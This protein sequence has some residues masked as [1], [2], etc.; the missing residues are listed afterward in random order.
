M[1]GPADRS[2]LRV[3]A[4]PESRVSASGV[5]L[6]LRLP[7][8][9]RTSPSSTR[10]PAHSLERAAMLPGV[11]TAAIAGN[12]PLDPGFTNSFTIVGREAEAAFV[13]RDLAAPGLAI[14][15]PG[16]EPAAT[17]ADGCCSTPIRPQA[18]PVVLI[19][20]G[21]G[22]AVLSVGRSDRR[23]HAVLGHVAHDCRRRC[24][25]A[26]PRC[27]QHRRR[28][29]PTLRSHRHHLRAA[30]SCCARPN[31]PSTLAASAERVIHEIDPGLAVF[32]VE[33]LDLTISRSISQ[34][35]FTTALLGGFA[36]LALILAA[37]GIHG[38]VSYNVERRRRRSGSGWRSAPAGRTSTG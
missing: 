24:E 22:A 37:V 16:G 38:L 28:L 3:G 35:R 33:P 19:N 32:A 1:E 26:V 31:S 25:R 18:A 21:R 29:P 23:P 13:A 4:G 6:P 10:S 17:S 27:S 14:V 34:R 9:G 7:P 8:A 11:E 20:R 5:A 2:G 30:S 15:F 12:H 36:L